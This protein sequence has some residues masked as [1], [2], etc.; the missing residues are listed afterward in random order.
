M[1]GDDQDHHADRQH[2]DVGVLEHDVGD[3]ARA[4]QDT[5]GQGGEQRH[6]HDERDVD[7][8]LPQVAHDQG[9]RITGADVQR[10]SGGALC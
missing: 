4:E 1:A 10:G 9:E 6:D 7:A 8:A 3:V 2:Q 5:V